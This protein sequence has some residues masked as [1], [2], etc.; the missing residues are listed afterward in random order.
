M[1]SSDLKLEGAILKPT[2]LFM[3]IILD[4]VNRNGP[5]GPYG[6]LAQDACVGRDNRLLTRATCA[7]YPLVLAVDRFLMKLMIQSCV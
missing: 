6:Y 1:C 7:T 4:C 2:V 3:I 5:Y